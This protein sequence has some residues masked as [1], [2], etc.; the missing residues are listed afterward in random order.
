MCFGHMKNMDC[1][2][3]EPRMREA[4]VFIH[5]LMYEEQ[6]VHNKKFQTWNIKPGMVHHQ[7]RLAGTY[8]TGSFPLFVFQHLTQQS[9][10]RTKG[11][12]N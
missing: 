9:T 6:H 8:V 5:K 2:T 3:E 7:S 10:S 1:H 4:N 12:F 11:L